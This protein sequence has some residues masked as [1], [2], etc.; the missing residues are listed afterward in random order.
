MIRKEPGNPCT[1]GNFSDI[2]IVGDAYMYVC[3]RGRRALNLAPKAFLNSNVALMSYWL[4]AIYFVICEISY[5]KQNHS[6]RSVTVLWF[7]PEI[8]FTI[9]E[10]YRLVQTNMNKQFKLAIKEKIK[11][12]L[13][14]V[15]PMKTCRENTAIDLLI[16]N[17][18]IRW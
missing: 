11:V 12:K 3:R 9:S 7:C 4:Q 8:L 17:L 5:R 2:S 15:H 13:R 1:V 18:G 14:P 6:T 10:I 16:F